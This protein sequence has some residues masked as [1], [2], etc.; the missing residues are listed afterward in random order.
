MPTPEDFSLRRIAV[1]AF[2]PSAIWAVGNGA[3]V[4][5]I[6]LS[7]REL[8][9]SLSWAAILVGLTAAA[10]FV[11]AVPAGVFVARVGE[12]RGLMIAAALDAL[13]ALICWWAPNLGVLALGLLLMGPA[14]AV[15]LISR[16]SYLTMAAPVHLRARAMSMLGGV[17][18]IGW[19]V[20]PFLGAAVVSLVGETRTAYA[21]AAVAGLL[22][23]ALVH[24]APDLD[25][26]DRAAGEVEPIR[27]REVVR[28][29][30]RVL[31]TVGVGVLVIGLARSARVVGLPLWGE[32]IGLD[33]A[34]ISL[35]FGASVLVEVLV[36]YP[37]GMLMDRRGRVIVAVPATILL[38][39]SLL[40]LPLTSTLVGITALA[41]LSGL[42]NGL[43]SGIVMTLGADAAP[44]VGRAQ[45]L[46][47]WRLLSL[48][49]HNGSPLAIAG[50]TAIAG[51]APAL[52]VVGAVSV[53]GAGWLA[54]WLPRYD[55]RRRADGIR[56]PALGDHSPR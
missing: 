9:A 34:Q 14:S 47:V 44:S 45:F 36:F 52:V 54:F 43:G 41:L 5:I 1:P 17:T 22:A 11:V 26:E 32:Q 15:F 19:F 49:G 12:Q 55:P 21:V 40:L 38:G 24:F 48:V 6:A 33:A 30:R 13:A 10:E 27:V 37:A 4:P 42:G 18:R 50:I 35:L 16:Q 51:L 8:G 20:G 3:T 39:L 31:S 23:L 7:A 2:G 46:S 29:H 56:P 53:V 28:A 25:L